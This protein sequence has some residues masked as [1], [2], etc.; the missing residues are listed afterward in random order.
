MDTSIKRH[1]NGATLV[2]AMLMLLVLTVLG[3]ASM[4][5]SRLEER[6]AGNSRDVNLAF[7]G[8][9]AGL[10]DAEERVRAWNEFTVPA[11]CI[12]APCSVWQRNFL[13][14]D[15]RDQTLAW[16]NTNATEYGVAG[17]QEVTE[18]TRDPLV[19]VEDLDF[20]ADSAA[21]TP[22]YSHQTGRSFYR[23]TADSAG[24]S[25]TAEV[26]LESTFV[27]RYW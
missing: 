9:E 16:W 23:V 24:A 18:I 2:V 11:S 22:G 3:I 14:P 10:R 27:Q 25:N 12:A 17:A 15:L 21:L 5:V 8:A 13:P 1:Q 26:V 7:Q 4:Q 20:V 19:V 6:M